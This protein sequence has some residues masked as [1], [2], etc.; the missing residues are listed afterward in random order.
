MSK[1]RNGHKAKH[2]DMP[3]DANFERKLAA[4]RPR[5]LREITPEILAAMQSPTASTATQAIA[6]QW[7]TYE[8]KSRSQFAVGLCCFLLG[9]LAMFVLMT[10]FFDRT[11]TRPQTLLANKPPRTWTVPLDMK[12]LDGVTSPAELAS[13]IRRQPVIVLNPEPAETPYTQRDILRAFQDSPRL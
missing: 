1:H 8:R 12:D 9:A 13:K 3:D 10:C 4:H 11:P 5:L 6:A 7:Q 2:K